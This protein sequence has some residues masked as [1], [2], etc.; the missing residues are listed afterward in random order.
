MF[1][2]A[3]VINPDPP[4]NVQLP[5][6]IT[7][8]FPFKVAVVAQTLCDAPAF[9]IVGFA[10]CCMVT[11]DVLAGQTP[12]VIC[13]SKSFIPMPKPN[14]CEFGKVGDTTKPGPLITFQEPTPTIGVL[15]ASV[16][17]L[18]QIVCDGPAFETVG[19]LSLVIVT[20]EIEFGQTPLLIVQRKTFA[21]TPNALMP[22]VGDVGVVIN[23]AP[24]INVQLPVPT[25]GVL[26][27]MV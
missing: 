26:P 10:S 17:V 25:A 14:T 20:F 19:K 24:E 16:A 2:V 27:V 6:P 13:H 5:V 11:V 4:I 7:G 1:D 3:V 21:P 18:A 8:K 23:P 12:F 22:V 15:P 9:D